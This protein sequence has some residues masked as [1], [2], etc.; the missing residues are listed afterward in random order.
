MLTVELHEDEA[1]KNA[2]EEVDAKDERNLSVERRS[3][4]WNNNRGYSILVEE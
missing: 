3:D 1:R 2:G 4:Q